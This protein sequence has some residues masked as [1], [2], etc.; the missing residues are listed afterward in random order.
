[1]C[2]EP[3]CKLGASHFKRCFGD[4]PIETQERLLKVIVGMTKAS[5][6]IVLPEHS[7]YLKN[8]R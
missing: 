4:L 6:N 1:M 3:D 8:L 2:Y 5:N 7:N